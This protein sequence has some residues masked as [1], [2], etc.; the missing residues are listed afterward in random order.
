MLEAM[1]IVNGSRAYEETA[2][3]HVATAERLA[4][5]FV[6]AMES[7]D[8]AGVPLSTVQKIAVVEA[9]L[10]EFDG[11]AAHLRSLESVGRM[12]RDLGRP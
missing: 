1:S 2:I 6:V 3:A 12:L 9:L 4:R 10:L 7:C 11:F 8:E 5:G